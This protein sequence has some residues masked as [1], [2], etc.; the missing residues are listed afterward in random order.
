MFKYTLAMLMLPPDSL[1]SLFD[2]MCMH[3][4][5]NTGLH[6][7][8]QLEERAASIKEFNLQN[9]WRKRGMAMIPTKFGISFTAK[10]MNQ[11]GALVHMYV[12]AHFSSDSAR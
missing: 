5:D 2:H 8:A 9:R 4:Y 3:R 7:S 10:F 11:G 12:T 1:L 6:E